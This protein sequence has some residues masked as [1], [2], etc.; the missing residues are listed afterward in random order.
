MIS[1]LE[2][3][4]IPIGFGKEYAENP[5]DFHVQN[6][7]APVLLLLEANDVSSQLEP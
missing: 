1:H 2:N 4:T 7:T 5:V 6:N 3:Y